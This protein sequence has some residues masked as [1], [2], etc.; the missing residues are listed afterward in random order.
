MYA[1]ID[2]NNFFVSCERLF[3]P[4]LHSI[5][6]V[7]LS[8]NDGCA[9]SRSNEAKRLGVAMGEPIFKL[10]SRFT[11]IAGNDL[12]G[13]YI[14]AQKHPDWIT[15]LRRASTAAADPEQ[16]YIT[17]VTP[18]G[19]LP[20]LVV[21]SANFELYGDISER[22]TALLATVAP[23]IEVYSVDESFL[24]LTELA[25]NDYTAWGITLQR[26][27][28]QTVGI[29]VSVGIAPTKT[30]CKVANHYAKTH[31]DC[32][33]AFYVN[34]H[35]NTNPASFIQPLEVLRHTPVNDI[36]G[37]G[38]RL[39]PKLHAEGIHTALDMMRMRPRHAQRLMGIHG[40]QMVYELNGIR[41]LALQVDHK[42]RQMICRGRQFG[43]DTNDLHVIMAAI[44]S[45]GAKAAKQ[46]RHEN[47][48]AT[49]AAVI[50]RTNRLKPNYQ[51]A[52]IPVRLYTPTADTGILCSHLAR[53]AAQ[54]APANLMYHK[55]DVILDDLVCTDSLQTDLLGSVD[56]IANA[57][58]TRR[59]HALDA[60]NARYGPGT[61][62]YAAENLSN[63]WCPRKT[64]A[65][66][67]YTTA[68]ASLPTVFVTASPP[69]YPKAQSR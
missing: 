68:W 9:I 3:R 12:R 22:I 2:S 42:P 31:P 32:Q 47:R 69:L 41:C 7:V 46:L 5:P 8:S 51:S 63:A 27:I 17:A 48:L 30:L 55:A 65:S 56:V 24:D 16:P 66:P 62:R 44:A 21:F 57:K 38:W 6:V 25:I 4:E 28:R 13:F 39:S 43:A 53:A 20:P 11:V 14:W 40:R 36:W 18:Y 10:R 33:G 59:M 23:H 54:H 61:L 34:P 15:R 64:M 1:L 37:V 49:R 45:L 67:P 50:L 52:Y 35:Q 26:S 19:T 58:S 29:P 60:L